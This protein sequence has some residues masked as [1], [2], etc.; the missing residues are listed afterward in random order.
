MCVLDTTCSGERFA[1]GCP[2][3]ASLAFV[4]VLLALFGPPQVLAG[5][6]LALAKGR[7]LVARR[8]LVDPNFVQSIVLLLE[9]SAEGALGVIV[10]RPAGVPPSKLLPD[11]NELA[12]YDGPVYLGG[13]VGLDTLVWVGRGC[14]SLHDVQPVFGEVCYGGSL[15]ALVAFARSAATPERLRLYVGYAG[16]GAGQL[17]RE[18]AHGDWQVIEAREERVF[19]DDPHSMWERLVPAPQPLETRVIDGATLLRGVASA[20]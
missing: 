3:A 12:G 13:P 15:E 5:T 11:V 1:R 16:W 6:P 17:E 14:A 4:L 10:N 9:Y 2:R 18:L 19:M 7:L 20:P 8:E